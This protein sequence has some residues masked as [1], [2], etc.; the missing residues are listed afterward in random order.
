MG[1]AAEHRFTLIPARQA[2]R[3]VLAAVATWGGL[4]LLIEVLRPYTADPGPP[5]K[6]FF[7]AMLPVALLLAAGPAW[8]LGGTLVVTMEPGRVLV[9]RDRPGRRGRPFVLV[10]PAGARPHFAVERMR[11][12]NRS[13]GVLLMSTGGAITRVEE[14]AGFSTLS[15]IAAT[16]NGQGA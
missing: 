2:A 12:R 14:V 16:L 8:G 11:G 4:W 1:D 15:E 3:I 9:R 5:L 10:V 7:L 6:G 13:Q